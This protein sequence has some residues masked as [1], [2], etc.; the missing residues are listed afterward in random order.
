MGY[1]SKRKEITKAE[2]IIKAYNVKTS[3][4]NKEIKFLSGGNQQKV[5]IGRSTCTEPK[6][7]IFDEPTKGID[8]G[9]KTEVYRLMKELA[10]KGIAIILISSEMDEIKKCANRIICMYHGEVTGECNYGSEKEEIL[11]AILGIKTSDE[12]DRLMS[13]EYENKQKASAADILKTLSRNSV[14]LI[15][16]VL[17][18]MM[19]IATIFSPH[20]LTIFNLQSLMRDIAFIGMVAVAQS[21]LLLIGE[22]DLSVG[23]IATLSG[24]LGGILMTSMKVNPFLAFAIGLLSGILFGMINGL[25]VTKLRLNSMVTTIGMQS[26]YGGITLVIT[27]GKAVTNIPD[28][29]FFLGKGNIGVFPIPFI[30]AIVV[31]IV[32][33]YFVT[34]TK[35]GRYI[36]AIGNSREASKIMGI[37]VDAVR[38]LI[39][40]IVGFISALAGMLY[41]A[42][43]G[44][45]QA[46]IGNNWPMNSIASS[47]IGGVSL[48][49]GVGSPVG[50]IIG[51]AII[52]VISNVIVLFGV[53][54]YWQEAVSG[55][56]VVIAIALPSLLTI[57]RECSVAKAKA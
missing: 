42:R 32:I 30:F 13:R 49:G 57:I 28:A 12:E 18:L 54:V 8:I 47:V 40:G 37:R 39:Y 22:L 31:L 41:V 16:S 35:T 43:L 11:K 38:V 25:L 24:V 48:T 1:L 10:E 50:A 15:G 44:S 53:N 4:L 9:A 56:V 34:K 7:L 26:L 36:Y 17:I 51:S 27:K 2:E 29:I 14:A 55:F 6:I 33:V 45:A 3:N 23:K 19:I 52:C 46:A 20:F 21:L 5:I